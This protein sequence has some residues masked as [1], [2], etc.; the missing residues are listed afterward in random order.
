MHDFSTVYMR[1]QKPGFWNPIEDEFHNRAFLFGDGLFETM[2]FSDGIL[3]DFA[4]HKLRLL[5][6]MRILSLYGEKLSTPEEL[7]AV[8]SSLLPSDTQARIRWNVFRAGM[9]KYTP[10]SNGIQETIQIQVLNFPPVIKN[11][12]FI[13]SQYILFPHP[14][15]NCKTSNALIY[16]LAN[17]ERKLRQQDEIILLDNYGHISEAGAA[18]LFWKKDDIFYTPALSTNCIAGVGRHKIIQHLQSLNLPVVEGEFTVEKLMEAD[19]IFTSNVTGISYLREVEGKVFNTDSEPMLEA[20]FIK[21][22]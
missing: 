14:W 4:L 3:V 9:G 12:T 8:I 1:K 17:Q 22:H 16:V 11:S 18:N 19:K 15:A 7:Q 5:K 2:V 13:S 20:L 6:G 21:R 10:E